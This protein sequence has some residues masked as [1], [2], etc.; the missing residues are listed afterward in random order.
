MP[1]EIER[2]FLVVG[3]GWRQ[4]ADAG[5]ALRQG[6]VVREGKASVRIRLAGNRGWIT[7]KSA[8]AGMVRDEFEYEIAAGEAADMLDRLCSGPLIEKTRYKVPHGGRIW[9][10][11]VFA[12][13]AAGLVLAEVELDAADAQ[14]DLPAWVGREVT[15]DPRYRNAAIGLAVP[16]DQECEGA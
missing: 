12:G 11:D 6:Y 8:R 10:V 7:L 13:T 4:G 2:K 14:V 9:E 5:R 16:T 15:D 1:I 3:D